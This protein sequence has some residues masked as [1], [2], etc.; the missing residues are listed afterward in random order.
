M[1]RVVTFAAATAL[2]AVVGG[3]AIYVK[4]DDWFVLPKARQLVA[5]KLNDPLSA[6]FR[7]DRLIDYNWHCGEVNGKNAM[8]GYVGFRRF[9]SG[10]INKEVY[11]ERTGMVGE[12]TTAEVLLLAD[13]VIDR[14]KAQNAMKAKDP[15]FKYP[16]ESDA[17]RYDRARGEV[18]E[19]HWKAIC[20]KA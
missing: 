19:D 11:L 2:I 17:D 7:N 14:M 9:I 6:Q 8:G 4:Y 12:E 13:K 1:N 15:D 3:F 5:D 18:F 20:E 10:R 16:N